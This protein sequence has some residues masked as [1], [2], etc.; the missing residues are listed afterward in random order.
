M[1]IDAE[2]RELILTNDPAEQHEF[3]KAVYQTPV[4]QRFLAEFELTN[5]NL[6]IV[7]AATAKLFPGLPVTESRFVTALR[8]SM[9]AGDLQRKPAAPVVASTPSPEVPRDK[10]GRPLTEAQQRWSEYR[11]FSETHSMDEV[12]ARKRID[13]GYRNFVEKNCEREGVSEGPFKVLNGVRQLPKSDTPAELVAWVAEYL[14]TPA[15]QVRKLCLAS[16]N[17]LGY[18]KFNAMLELAASKNLI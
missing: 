16:T 10:N 18:V 11:Q 1:R 2:T 6:D 8:L 17:P 3:G 9:D 14:R 4:G 7:Q 13:P 12:R 5:E 15:D